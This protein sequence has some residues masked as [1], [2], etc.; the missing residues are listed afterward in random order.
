MEREGEPISA[1]PWRNR[2][3]PTRVGSPG[4]FISLLARPSALSTPPSPCIDV[5]SYAMSAPK[6]YSWDDLKSSEA[7]S[8][9]GLL[10]LIH[11]K[12][13]S[14]SASRSPPATSRWLITRDRNS[15]RDQQVPRRG[16]LTR[17][18]LRKVPS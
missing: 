5:R 15:L 3:E 2:G 9:D 8:K 16:E 7:K 11:G 14:L 12:G 13:Q 18:A 4:F 1:V 17:I 10:M 6:T